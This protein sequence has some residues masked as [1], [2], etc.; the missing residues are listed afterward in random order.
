MNKIGIMDK[1]GNH[2]IY[3]KFDL[4]EDTNNEYYIVSKGSKYGVLKGNGVS[5]IPLSY[6]LIEYN[7]KTN[8]YLALRRS[9]WEEII[10]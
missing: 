5:T 2:L 1:L 7:V 4:L 3:P 10:P 6:D 8:N 9:R